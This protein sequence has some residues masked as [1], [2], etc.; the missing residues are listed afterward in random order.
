M[1]LRF[2]IQRPGS[3]YYAAVDRRYR[4]SE[5]LAAWIRANVRGYVEAE[6]QRLIRRVQ[7][8]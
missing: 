2:E 4:I 6:V 5:R 7:N 8:G 1:V 3:A